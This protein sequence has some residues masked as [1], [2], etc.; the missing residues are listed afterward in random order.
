MKD[1]LIVNEECIGIM[2]P[3]KMGIHSYTNYSY[4]YLDLNAIRKSF[5]YRNFGHRSRN[6]ILKN[7]QG[8]NLKQRYFHSLVK[9]AISKLQ[10]FYK[11]IL[12][13]RPDLLDNA[14]LEML[15]GLTG[16]FIAYYWDSV[17]CI[18]RKLEIAHYF[19]RVL[20]FDPE[21]CNK[22]GFEFQ[23]NFFFY[24]NVEAEVHERVYN[25][26]T[27]DDRRKI[28]EQVAVCLEKNKI[29]YLFKAVKARSFKNRYIRFTRLLTYQQM[30]HE[31]AG[32]TVL[33]DI[34]RNGQTGL[35]LR[36]LEALGLHK[37]LITTNSDIRNYPFYH[38]DN[39]F[40]VDPENID[41]DPAFFRTPYRTVPPG[42]REQYHIRNWLKNVLSDS[43]MA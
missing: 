8:S 25:L 15:R 10:P 24:E 21:D 41:I 27:Y 5:R 1:I 2:I 23:P 35:T 9:D 13:I 11:K 7:L 39:I 26:S 3:L 40:I 20:S 31:I 12:V 36:P 32:S 42:I 30:I 6:F 19:D 18:P 43:V 38:P 17:E 29:P 34:V 22:Y 37:K 33:L 28:I 4:D 16:Q 14:H